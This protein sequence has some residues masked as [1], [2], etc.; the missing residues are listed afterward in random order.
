MR[1]HVES[2][3]PGTRSAFESLIELTSTVSERAL[4]RP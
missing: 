2:E 4:T 1:K 3:A